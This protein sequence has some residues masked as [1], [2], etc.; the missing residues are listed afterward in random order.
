MKLAIGQNSLKK[1]VYK[2]RGVSRV[3]PFIKRIVSEAS[4]LSDPVL[5]LSVGRVSNKVSDVLNIAA[6]CQCSIDL[7]V[8]VHRSVKDKVIAALD[9][10]DALKVRSMSIKDD[11]DLPNFLA[12]QQGYYLQE[13]INFDEASIGF[14]KPDFSNFLIDNFDQNTKSAA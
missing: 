1:E 8:V 3:E 9:Q 13:G 12:S 4:K 2:V 11:G 14:N 6:D 7:H 10:A 5:Y